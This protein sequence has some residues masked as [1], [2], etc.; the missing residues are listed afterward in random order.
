MRTTLTNL[1]VDRLDVVFESDSAGAVLTLV[2][3]GDYL[4]VL[5][6]LS[7][8]GRVA[9]GELA[10]LPTRQTGPERSIGIITRTDIAQSVTIME[11]RDTLRLGIMNVMPL[12]KRISDRCDRLG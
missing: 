11:L 8:A 10:V 3:D 7:V 6:L 9:S 2:R 1:G 12:M 4:T 5:P